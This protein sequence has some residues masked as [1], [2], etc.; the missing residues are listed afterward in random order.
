ADIYSIG[1]VIYEIIF[2][3][4]PFYNLTTY[5]QLQQ[6]VGEAGLTPDIPDCMKID[7]KLEQLMKSSWSFDP[8]RRPEVKEL[9]ETLEETVHIYSQE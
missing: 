4:E 1:L 2:E 7:P 5:D 9:L 3:Q 6:Q 8:S